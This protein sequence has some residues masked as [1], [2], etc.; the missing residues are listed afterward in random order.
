[1]NP[2]HIHLLLNHLPTVGFSI[3][4]GIFV[5]A[6]AGK[7]DDL[8]RVSL[9]LFFLTAAFTIT[10][11]V[12]GSDAQEAI[13]ESPGVSVPLISEHETAALIAFVFMQI[14]GFFSW[15]ALWTLRRV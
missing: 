2:V 7:R 3:G 12:S 5:V 14:T 11:Y 10:T 15:I 13:K 8:I 6:L 4:L 1:M 9:V